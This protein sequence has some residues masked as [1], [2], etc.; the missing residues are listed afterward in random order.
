MHRFIDHFPDKSGLAAA[1]DSHSA[2]TLDLSIVI[3][4]TETILI[5]LP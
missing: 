5:S 1:Y 4:Q 3:G 2:L